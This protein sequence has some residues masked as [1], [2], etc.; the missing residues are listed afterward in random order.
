MAEGKKEEKKISLEETM[1]RI[2]PLFIMMMLFPLIGM[3]AAMIIIYII[4][5]KNLIL[6]ET[7]ILFSMIFFVVTTYLVYMKMGEM[8]KRAK[9]A[10]Q[11]PSGSAT[12]PG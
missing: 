8:G 10:E 3:I 11:A 4:Q 7:L 12:P 2:R 5:P 6:I 9:A 1:R